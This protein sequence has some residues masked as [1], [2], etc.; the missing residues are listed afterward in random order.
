M[1]SMEMMRRYVDHL[2]AGEFEEAAEYWADDI[3]GHVFGDNAL[4]G[5]YAGKQGAAAYGAKAMSMVDSNQIEEH[6]LLVSDQHAVLLAVGHSKRNGK[7]ISSKTVIVYHTEGDK[8][9]EW[10][11]VPQDQKALDEFLS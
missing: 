7:Q 11:A 8:I 2:T 10:W 6:D 9:T 5:T 4:S 1:A 3:V